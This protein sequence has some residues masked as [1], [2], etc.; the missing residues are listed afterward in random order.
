V[1]QKNPEVYFFRAFQAFDLENSLKF[2]NILI[3]TNSTKQGIQQFLF[4]LNEL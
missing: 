2:K 1:A 4:Y 3:L